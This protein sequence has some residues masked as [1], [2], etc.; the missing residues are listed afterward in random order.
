MFSMFKE[1]RDRWRRDKMMTVLEERSI[2][3]FMDAVDHIGLI[4]PKG[5]D[6]ECGI[7]DRPFRLLSFSPLAVAVGTLVRNQNI[8]PKE[9]V[10]EILGRLNKRKQ[11]KFIALAS[12]RH[13][14]V[15]ELLDKALLEYNKQTAEIKKKLKEN[16]AIGRGLDTVK[17][18]LGPQI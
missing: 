8:T 14:V 5:Y 17:R 2:R 13:P 4:Y 1:L 3:E 7:C 15:K 6:Q 16:R 11:K 10:W 12:K 9:V 18:N